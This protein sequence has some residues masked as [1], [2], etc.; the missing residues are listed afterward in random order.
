MK[1]MFLQS[2]GFCRRNRLPAEYQIATYY[3]LCVYV[4]NSGFNIAGDP[5]ENNLFFFL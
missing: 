1:K 5:G 3:T 4:F 2:E